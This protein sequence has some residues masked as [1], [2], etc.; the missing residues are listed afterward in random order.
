MALNP[1]R[2]ELEIGELVLHG[3]APGDRH[4]IGAAVERE[5]ARLFAEQGVSPSLARNGEVARLD[6]SAF[7]VALGAGVESIGTQVA[8][9]VHRG[10]SR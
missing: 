8:Q 4:R 5:L 10:L 6:A 3:F 7:Q 2:I 9:S 1:A